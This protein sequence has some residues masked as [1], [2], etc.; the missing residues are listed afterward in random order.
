MT[1][2]Q[3]LLITLVLLSS[4]GTAAA[5]FW[6]NYINVK[7]QKMLSYY[8]DPATQI[9]IAQHVIKNSWLQNGEEVYK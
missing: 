1:H 4:M 7:H 5:V 9:K 3:L 6:A 8:Q 2:F